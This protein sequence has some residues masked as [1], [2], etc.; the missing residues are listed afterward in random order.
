[1]TGNLY[2][3]AIPLNFKGNFSFLIEVIDVA[4][5]RNTSEIVSI[6]VLGPNAVIDPTEWLVG[7]VSIDDL[8][9]QNFTLQ[10]NGSSTLRGRIILPNFVLIN[11]IS[12]SAC[13]NNFLIQTHDNGR[14]EV[15]EIFVDGTFST[16]SFVADDT[17]N[18][19]GAA[20]ADFDNDGDCDFATGGSDSNIHYYENN[21]VTPITGSSFASGV[22]VGTYSSSSWGM[23]TATGDFNEDSNFDF[24][25]SGNNAQLFLFSGNGDGTF[26]VG[27]V[28]ISV[29]DRPESLEV[30]L[31]DEGDE[32]DI[33]VGSS[34][35]I[36]ILLGTGEFKFR[37]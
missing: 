25:I 1:M 14:L 15:L 23:D 28:T 37:Q 19:R 9:K 3:I 22:L 30:G 10:N 7:N 4:G 27:A 35:R 31:F 12:G 17:N 32:L 29:Q 36:T 34:S 11:N 6:E 20:I 5:N 26:R 33:A 24:V 8:V 18:V 2:S 21:G 13:S 16:T